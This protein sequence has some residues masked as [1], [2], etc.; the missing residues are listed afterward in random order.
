MNPIQLPLAAFA[1]LATLLLAPSAA[2]AGPGH[3]HGNES[4]PTTTGNALPRFAASSEL[5]EMVGVVDGQRVTL[6]LDHA[7]DNSPVDNASLEVEL[8]GTRLSLKPHAA[9]EFEAVLPAALPPGLSAVTATIIT[10]SET[11][12]L[13]GEIDFHPDVHGADAAP[14]RSAKQLALWGIGGIATLGLLAWIARRTIA[15]RQ[16]VAGHVA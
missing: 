15:A 3:D 5:F 2:L 6:Y 13:A 9:G 12:L 16:L 7:A 8:A 4:T 14:P 10:P 11:D 1:L